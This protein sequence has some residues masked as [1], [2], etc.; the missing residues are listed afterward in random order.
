[1]SRAVAASGGAGRC[2][3]LVTIHTS[4]Y[5]TLLPSAV[6]SQHQFPAVYLSFVTDH[7][8][9]IMDWYWPMDS[10]DA[11]VYVFPRE[12][13]NAPCWHF[14]AQDCNGFVTPRTRFFWELNRIERDL[15]TLGDTARNN[16][17]AFYGRIPTALAVKITVAPHERETFT[18]PPIPATIRAAAREWA[19]SQRRRWRH[20][21][22]PFQYT[23][24]P[25]M[26]MAGRGTKEDLLWF[27]WR[28]NSLEGSSYSLEELRD[29]LLGDVTRDENPVLE[30]ALS[31]NLEAFLKDESQPTPSG[32]TLK[33]LRAWPT[34][35]RA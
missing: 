18:I 30:N 24:I 8:A 11:V 6:V 2:K 26:M 3:C 27:Q 31:R 32:L 14:N 21:T 29:I 4:T 7:L 23:G 28:I 16:E 1:M 20:C 5:D 10:T 22:D 35:P 19:R 25:N 34:R 12:L 17:L 9:E 15:P 13:L 33:Q